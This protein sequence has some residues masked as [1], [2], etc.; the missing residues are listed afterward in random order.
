MPT[1]LTCER[2]FRWRACLVT[3]ACGAKVDTA[4]S[5]E[6]CHLIGASIYFPS[7]SHKNLN[8]SPESWLRITLFANLGNTWLDGCSD[9]SRGPKSSNNYTPTSIIVT[10]SYSLEKKLNPDQGVSLAR[11]STTCTQVYKCIS[12]SILRPEGLRLSNL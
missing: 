10:G 12:I 7:S 6:Q 11:N 9:Y 3:H 2:V 8:F 4:M 5:S 1:P